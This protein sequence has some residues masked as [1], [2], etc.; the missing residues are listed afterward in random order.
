LTDVIGA[1]G[2]KIF[3]LAITDYEVFR[4]PLFKPGFLG[5]KWP[6]IDYYVE[7]LGVTNLNPFFFAQVKSTAGKLEKNAVVLRIAA[8]KSKCKLLF[9]LPGPTY[10][11]GVHEP[12]KKAYILSVHQKPKRGVYR[13]PL[14]YELTPQNLKILHAEVK[15]FWRTTTN[16]PLQSHFL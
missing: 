6:I 4:K 9:E 5:D 1:R 7:L 8:Q 16:K 13:I 11:V 12:T 2:E 3:E 15:A 10:I 14:K